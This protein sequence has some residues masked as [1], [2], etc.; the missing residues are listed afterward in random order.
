MLH[1]RLTSDLDSLDVRLTKGRKA[2][3]DSRPIFTDSSKEQPLSPPS[4]M[5]ATMT[6][7]PR[8][9]VVYRPALPS[10]PS[11]PLGPATRCVMKHIDE[12]ARRHTVVPT[13]A[14]DEVILP[15]N[16]FNQL[17]AC[18]VSAASECFTVVDE[19]AIEESEDPSDHEA[20]TFAEE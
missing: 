17:E 13:Y 8:H 6:G 16:E 5:A 14:L 4:Q 9:H 20:E 19:N 3:N 18:L 11:S 2:S 10:A 1:K 15:R 12:C 7:P